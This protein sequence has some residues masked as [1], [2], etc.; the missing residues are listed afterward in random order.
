MG[1]ATVNLEF[2]TLR[3]LLGIPADM[4]ITHITP[5]PGGIVRIHLKSDKFSTDN[6]GGWSSMIIPLDQIRKM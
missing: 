3:E 6:P 4:E 2:E 5:A 1:I